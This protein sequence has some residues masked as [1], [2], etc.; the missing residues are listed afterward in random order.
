MHYTVSLYSYQCFHFGLQQAVHLL[1]D[2]SY[3]TL[4]VS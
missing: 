4:L 2:V 3:V 1:L